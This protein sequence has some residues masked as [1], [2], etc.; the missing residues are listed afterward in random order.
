MRRGASTSFNGGLVLATVAINTP[1]VR[2]CHVDDG[3]KAPAVGLADSGSLG[4]ARPG[5]RWCRD[6]RPRCVDGSMAA[7]LSTTNLSGPRLR[8]CRNRNS[9]RRVADRRCDRVVA[10]V[11]L[12]CPRNRAVHQFDVC[13]TLPCQAVGCCDADFSFW[14]RHMRRMT[15]LARWRLWARL[16][17]RRVLPS[18]VLR[19]R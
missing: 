2:S 12:C 18:A 8:R 11:E 5:R 15:R 6:R 13:L 1:R 4:W 14:S 7:P 17:S 9:C 19:A 16:A 3:G 10:R